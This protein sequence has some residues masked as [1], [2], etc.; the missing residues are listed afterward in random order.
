MY[1]TKN[2]LVN[3]FMAIA[4]I[5]LVAGFALAELKPRQS[6]GLLLD[7]YHRNMTRLETNNLG[8]P[9]VVESFE[10]D[11]KVHVDVYGVFA[12]PFS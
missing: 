8:L 7:A 4:M 10:K 3:L 6:E 9:L 1:T 2:I 12:H 11:D 5:L